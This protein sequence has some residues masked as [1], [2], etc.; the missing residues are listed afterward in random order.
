M[1]SWFLFLYANIHIY[2]VYDK[3]KGGYDG[4]YG[5][6]WGTKGKTFIPINMGIYIYING[7]KKV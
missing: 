5:I 1:I 7:D 2:N 6:F 4:Q 3:K